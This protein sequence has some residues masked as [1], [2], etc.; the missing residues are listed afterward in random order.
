MKWRY[1]ATTWKLQSTDFL[2]KSEEKN[3]ERFYS[4]YGI[5]IRLWCSL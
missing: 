4:L 3:P 1:K 5:S 2:A